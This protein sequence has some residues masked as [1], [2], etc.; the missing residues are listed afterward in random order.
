MH[1]RK[2]GKKIIIRK[3]NKC[4]KIFNFS[5]GYTDVHRVERKSNVFELQCR[6]SIVL[7]D[8]ENVFHGFR[9]KFSKTS[10]SKIFDR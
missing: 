6:K 1:E 7:I 10:P 2:K 8:N 5:H 9:I 3:Y 4:I